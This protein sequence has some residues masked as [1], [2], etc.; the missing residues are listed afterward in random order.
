[1]LTPTPLDRQYEIARGDDLRILVVGAGIAGI[2]V[3]QL[4]RRDGRHPV[5][6]ERSRDEG[7][8]GYMLALMPMVDGAIDDLG[9]REQY[10]QD[11]TPL[12]W[13]S[14]H[15]STGRKGRRDSL[16]RILARYGDYRGIGRGELIDVL[17]VNGC[18]ASF[19]TTV[20]A[21][22]EQSAATAVTMRTGHEEVELDF[23]LVVVADGIHSS[24][25]ALALGNRPVGTVDTGWGGWVVW[26]PA[27]TEPDLGAELW[28]A[29]FFLGGYPIKGRLGV[30]IGGPNEETAV[31]A[32][33]F[34]D[35]VRS[36]LTTIGP[37]LESMLTAVAT[38]P[39][40]YYWPLTDCRASEW[41]VGRTILLGDAAAGF[42]PTAGIGAGMA[43]ESA[44]VLARML[45]T[46]ERDSVPSRLGAFEKSQR[47]RVET[48]QQTS[49]RL[50]AL[51]F[52]RSRVLAVIRDLAMK[53]MSVEAALK[54][55]QRLLADRPEL[56]TV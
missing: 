39:D 10:R 25:R 35:G 52:R 38:E 3:A 13:Y 17:S 4:L 24:T 1:M 33:A 6:V 22:S 54:P 9:I 29:G 20:T 43:M 2:T 47:P 49:R 14:I 46:A 32:T 30:I 34:V 48:A 5:L 40:P 8:P 45:R 28:G 7:H 44:W 53:V 11:S 27:H 18:D 31:G 55:I 15:S 26:A 50:A 21:I 37:L 23:D 56:D 42:L 16:A 19:D 12:N 36:K 51:M 41:A